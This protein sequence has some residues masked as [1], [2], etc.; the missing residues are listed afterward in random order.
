MLLGIA[1]HAA[2]PDVPYWRPG[3]AGGG[4][5][6]GF[7]E[8]VHGFRMPLFFI[9]SG[10][11]TTMLWRRRGLSELIGHR[12]RRIGL[13]LLASVVIVLPLVVAGILIG[14]EISGTD[15]NAVETT[16]TYADEWQGVDDETYDDWAFGFAHL[17]FLWFLL[18]LIAGF[19]AIASAVGRLA[20]LRGRDRPVPARLVTAALLIVPPLALVPADRMVEPIFGPD[21]SDAFI[22]DGTVLAY[23][24]CFFA[25]GALAFDR[26][27]RNGGALI[28]AV[29]RWWPAQLAVGSF[30]LFPLGLSLMDDHWTASALVQTA[31]AWTISFGLLGGFRQFLSA[32]NQR[33]RWLSDSAY[34]MY[35]MHLPLIYVAQ[36]VVAR[37]DLSPVLGFALICAVVVPA[38]AASYRYWVRYTP[39]GTLLNGPRNRPANE[40]NRAR[41]AEPP[42]TPAT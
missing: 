20:S 31:F 21:T 15:I 2:L 28:D 10:Y 7:F 8:F 25:F 6:F 29:G 24:A 38:L 16:G 40:A 5:L 19:A 34:W 11:F 30:V 9:L 41:G 42:S 37:L 26:R 35:L 17:W 33:V 14:Y 4:F 13:P 22:P 18:W 12:L 3:D 1:L 32:T 27:T 39:I 23:Y 36:G